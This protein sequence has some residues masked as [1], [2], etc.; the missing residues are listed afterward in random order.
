MVN[1]PTYTSWTWT[2][3]A[4]NKFMWRERERESGIDWSSF[5][6]SQ[7]TSSML[8]AS[9]CWST[10]PTNGFHSKSLWALEKIG[11]H[12][13]RYGICLVRIGLNRR[14]WWEAA[15]SGTTCVC[16]RERERE[17]EK[18]TNCCLWLIVCA[19]YLLASNWRGQASKW[20]HFEKDDDNDKDNDNDKVWDAACCYWIPNYLHK[21]AGM[22]VWRHMLRCRAFSTQH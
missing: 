14:R 15:T 6:T 10:W 12:K 7:R 17:G 20:G 8:A 16:A 18:L 19:P 4:A 22:P 21:L 2:R 11:S 9:W 13:A 1:C 5:C 3:S